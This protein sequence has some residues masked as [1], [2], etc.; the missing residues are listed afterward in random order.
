MGTSSVGLSLLG[1]CQCSHRPRLS[2]PLGNGRARLWGW[3]A[4]EPTSASQAHWGGDR[5]P[6]R[7]GLLPVALGHHVPC[8]DGKAC[9][10]CACVP[11]ERAANPDG[12]SEGPARR[13]S[14]S[15]GTVCRGSFLE[16]RVRSCG[17]WGLGLSWRTWHLRDQ[18][19]VG[20]DSVMQQGEGPALGVGALCAG[21]GVKATPQPSPP[22]HPVQ[23]SPQPRGS[24]LV[25][26]QSSGRW[27]R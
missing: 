7:F 15:L 14:L 26:P 18:V 27:P 6:C 13:P 3:G 19:G 24:M 1:R 25:W 12:G 2:G 17:Q 11:R 23:S 8:G 4:G 20:E 9:L 10:Q 5:R 16:C 21:G 22:P